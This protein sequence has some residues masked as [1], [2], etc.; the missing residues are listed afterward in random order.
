MFTFCSK[1]LLTIDGPRP[2]FRTR[3]NNRHLDCFYLTLLFI[4][5]TYFSAGLK[6]VVMA[7]P[8]ARIVQN[9]EGLLRCGEAT[10][11]PG[12]P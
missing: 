2:K 6:P 10:Y 8:Q 4:S 12:H 1:V 11:G 3:S 9:G 7:V 5:K